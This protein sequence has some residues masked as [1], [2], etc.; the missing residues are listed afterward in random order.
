MLD[1]MVRLVYQPVVNLLGLRPSRW[2]AVMADGFL[3]TALAFT[4]YR[5]TES[6]TEFLALRT[7]HVLGAVI[8]HWWMRWCASNGTAARNGPM[9]LMH[10]YMRTIILGLAIQDALL[11]HAVAAAPELYMPG[12]IARSALQTAEDVFGA[13]ALYLSVCETPATQRRTA[14]NTFA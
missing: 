4:V 11:L 7:M 1:P 8:I 14:L 6:G 3:I 10:V 5:F 12:S 13:S 2:A 9:G